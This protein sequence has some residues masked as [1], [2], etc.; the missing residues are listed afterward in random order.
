MGFS[1][2]NDS[3]DPDPQKERQDS[4]PRSDSDSLYVSRL[5]VRI[6][7]QT[8]CIDPDCSFGLGLGL[9][10]RIW[11]PRSDS[12]SDSLYESGLPFP[13]RT[14]RYRVND[15]CFGCEGEVDRER[16]LLLQAEGVLFVRSS[17]FVG[18]NKF[19]RCSRGEDAKT[20]LI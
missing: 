4:T 18:A 20:R 8:P 3:E 6:G 1:F 15:R 5:P 17:C 11:T 9:P 16:M 13:I 7:T 10:L 14:P 12:V 2:R 19:L